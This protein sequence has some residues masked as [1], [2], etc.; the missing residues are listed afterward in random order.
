VEGGILA[1]TS[2]REDDFAGALKGLRLEAGLTQAELASRSELTAAYISQLESLKKPPPSD[3]VVR[4]IAGALSRDPEALLELAHL[5]KTPKD[6]RKKYRILDARLRRQRK[7]TRVLLDDM[8]PLTLFNFMRRPDYMERASSG[9]RVPSRGKSVLAKLRARIGKVDTFRS[10][11]SESRE[12]INGLA[13]E[14]R[15]ALVETLR[16][17]T[18]WEGAGVSPAEKQAGPAVREIP[19]F[20]AVPPAP[21]SGF[22]DRARGFLPVVASRWKKSRWA[23]SVSDDT[24]FPRLEK[25]DVLLLDEAT[26]ARNGDIVAALLEDGSAVIGRYMKLDRE[27]EITPANP[28][29]PPRCFPRVRGKGKS[30]TLRGVGV[31]VIRT[32]RPPP[33]RQNP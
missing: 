25:G 15:E 26:V 16:E 9:R 31:E 3:E 20:D 23:L 24:M 7:I 18:A 13:E 5:D 27:I 6:V 19:V 11:R 28:N 32:L 2:K 8:L 22:L 12:A 14:E 33:L 30:Y 1:R 29:H 17:M 4:R 10:F 21:A